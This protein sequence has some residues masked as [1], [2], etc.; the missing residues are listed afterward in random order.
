MSSVS[1]YVLQQGESNF[2]SPD[3]PTWELYST[4][5]HCGLC[6]SHCPTYRVLGTEMDSP[7]GR[8]YQVLQV[9]SG[10][11]P[12]GKS[13]V[14]HI[15]RCLD[16]RACESVCPSGVEY[17]RIVERARAEI[18]VNYRR[19]L[20]Q[21]VL[22]RIGYAIIADWGKLFSA[23]HFLRFAQDSGLQ[24][25]AEKSGLLRLLGLKQ[26]AALAPRISRSFF[27]DEYGK[28]FPA[29]GERRGRVAFLGG[30][31]ASVA[32]ADLNRAT[33][34][35]LQAN[36]VEVY[37][38]GLQ[39]CCGALHAHAGLREEARALARQNINVFLAAEC[40]AIVTNAAGCG[41]TMKEYHDLLGA[42]PAYAARAAEFSAKVRDISEYLTHIGLRPPARK[43]GARVIY[44]DACHLLHGQKIKSA[45]RELLRALG[46]ELVELPHPDQ[47]CGS[48]GAYNVVQNQLS[49]QVLAAKMDDIQSVT[50]D[51]I[52]T[53]NVGCM[54]QLRY[55]IAQ[56]GQS[57]PV[58]HVIELLDEAYAA[59]TM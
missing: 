23:A 15:D 19:P 34:R 45:P 11:L 41:S 53:A 39:K 58:K 31:I 9:D 2:R 49:M 42:D 17:G 29:A 44:Q 22:R 8:I 35:V 14:T 54:L 1:P 10:R 52:A 57:T 26:V 3:R 40:D 32:F 59:P 50:A 36:G 43:L 51:A 7:R 13:F 28:T 33:I 12:I 30:C 4:C 46:A 18:A 16:C 55:G 21:R 5:I 27:F 38:P 25:F 37:V 24:A 56:R 20:L 6:L 47:C 48:A